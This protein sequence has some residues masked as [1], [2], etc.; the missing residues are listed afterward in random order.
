MTDLVGCQRGNCDHDSDCA[1]YNEPAY[2]N[3][4]CNCMLSKPV[5]FANSD[6][7][8]AITPSEKAHIIEQQK[9]GGEFVSAARTVEKFAIPLYTRQQLPPEQQEE[10]WKCFHCEEVFTDRELAALHFGQRIYD[11]PACQ[12]DA[13][14]LRD[15]EG[16]LTR[17]REEDTDLHREINGLHATHATALQREEEKGYARGLKDAGLTEQQEELERLRKEVVK[18]KWDMEALTLRLKD[19]EGFRA[20]L[21]TENAALKEKLK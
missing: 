11:T 4:T 15:L 3:G 9:Y 13:A 8:C 6:I 19:S 20:N 7:S 16:Q 21:E 12:I 14:H 10:S 17:Y 1:V 18:Q 2:P 5:M